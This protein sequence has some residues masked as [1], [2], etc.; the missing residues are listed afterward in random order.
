MF[1]TFMIESSFFSRTER[2]SP[3]FCGSLFLERLFRDADMLVLGIGVL[4]CSVNDFQ[5]GTVK[6]LVAG[7]VLAGL[8][9]AAR[10]TA[11][12]HQAEARG[13]LLLHFEL[14]A[15]CIAALLTHVF[16]RIPAGYL[17]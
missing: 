9:P 4:D 10:W 1:L 8:I 17:F 13:T 11:S 6:P 2:I 14:R 5:V 15:S 16:H 7:A 12:L 3:S